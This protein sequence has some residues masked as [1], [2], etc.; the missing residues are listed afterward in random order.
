MPSMMKDQLQ[1]SFPAQAAHTDEK[2]DWAV[3]YE[4][5]AAI[6]LRK[7]ASLIREEEEEEIF[8]RG[9]R[10]LRTLM[11]AA[12]IAARMKRQDEKE[13]DRD[14]G[15]KQPPS[16]NDEELRKIYRDVAAKVDRIEREQQ[17]GG[18]QA[19]DNCEGDRESAGAPATRNLGG[20]RS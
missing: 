3:L 20:E 16:F 10:A 4:R 19:A 1:K 15:K 7:S 17:T 2:A 12:E 6:A 14:D 8:D 9:A 11:G 5:I 18:V 13:Q